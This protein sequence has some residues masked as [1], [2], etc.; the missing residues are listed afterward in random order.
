MKR[1]ATAVLLM[2]LAVPAAAAPGGAFAGMTDDEI[3]SAIDAAVA[4]KKTTA[5]FNTALVR[6]LDDE[7]AG[8]RVRERAAWALGELGVKT[9]VSALVK[10]AGH[11]GLLVRSA[12]VTSLLR[13]RPASAIP[14]FIKIAQSDPILPLRQRAVIALG[15]FRSE[16]AI[17]PLVQLSSDP[18]PELRGAAALAM[19][20]T[21]SKKNDFSEIL[22]EMAADENSYVRERAERALEIA[23]G[24]SSEVLNQ[25]KSSDADIRLTAALYFEPKAGSRELG[26]LKD[27]WNTEPDD[28]VRD[29]LQRAIIATKRRIQVEKERRVAR[30][31][32]AREKAAAEAA[33]KTGTK[34]K[35]N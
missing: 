13:L 29:Q 19:A 24:K 28:D 3:V 15:A 7:T 1:F 11:K 34:T 32:A 20:A 14:V 26:A 21:H 10:A 17:E 12:A 2:A 9:A 8:I 23:R 16:K 27:A 6:A 22:T 4:K 18:A 35:T 5:A 30:E 25:L 31:K 33:G